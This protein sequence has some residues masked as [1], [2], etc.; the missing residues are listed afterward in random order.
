[1]ADVVK[2]TFDVSFQNP[3]STILAGKVNVTSFYCIVTASFLTEAIGDFVRKCFGY[4]FDSQKVQSL[5]SPVFHGRNAQRSFLTV[6][7]ENVKQA[8]GFCPIILP[9]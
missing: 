3:C 9:G 8:K 7:L 1:M 4:R 2:T 6:F 5:H